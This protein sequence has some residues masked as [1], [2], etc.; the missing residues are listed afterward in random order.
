MTRPRSPAP[1][2]PTAE[3]VPHYPQDRRKFQ[4]YSLADVDTST[5]HRC[6]LLL[7]QL[8][9]QH[10]A[11]RAG[12]RHPIRLRRR[13][14][15]KAPATAAPGPTVRRGSGRAA[16]PGRLSRQP[17]KRR[18]KLLDVRPPTFSPRSRPRPFNDPSFVCLQEVVAGQSGG[19]GGARRGGGMSG[20]ERALA[21]GLLTGRRRGGWDRG[22]GR[23][24]SC[25]QAEGWREV[26]AEE[27]QGEAEGVH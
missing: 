6:R 7:P 12:G 11:R 24:G 5:L 20:R 15:R 13:V 23:A 2:A 22:H 3:R 1:A 10:R 9:V 25:G 17:A 21:A 19:G 26:E 14:Q 8:P 18:G 27:G 16:L 4:R